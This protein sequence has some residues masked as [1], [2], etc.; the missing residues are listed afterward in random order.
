MDDTANLFLLAGIWSL[1][2]IVVVRLIP[3][4]W[5]ARIAVFALL[6]GVPFW[7]LPYGFY[8]LQKL[9]KDEG[10]LRVFASIVPQ[11]SV[12][13]DYPFDA[14]AKALLRFG[15]ASI[16][17]RSKTGEVTQHVGGT[18]EA[19]SQSKTRIVTSEYCVTFANN[20]HLP[21]RVIRHDFLIVRSKDAAV[22]GRHSVFDWF[23]MWWQEAASPVLGRGG[24]CREDPVQPVMAALRAGSN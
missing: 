17:S 1:I 2:A 12:C 24:E 9:C 8:N 19:L 14:S 5:P 15:F 3:I 7:E 13:V 18:S 22:V 21:W 16:E 23:G 6:V 11:K 4:K 10:K 20:N